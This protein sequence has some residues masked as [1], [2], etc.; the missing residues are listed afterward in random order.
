[1]KENFL[2]NT[3]EFTSQTDRNLSS[4]WGLIYCD[5]KYNDIREALDNKSNNIVIEGNLFYGAYGYGRDA[6]GIFIDHGRGDVQCND[7][8]ILNSQSYSMDSRY[9]K[10]NEASSV[11]NRYERNIVT[12]NYRLMA[13]VC[14]EG[15][16]KPVTNENI[17]LTTKNSKVL[18]IF[19]DEKDQQLM[20]E[21]SCSFNEGKVFVSEALYRLIKKSRAWRYNRN[22]VEKRG[23]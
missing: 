7:N 14:V 5:H 23:L 22:F 12:T 19:T 6:R 3:D 21:R 15:Q 10:R 2:Y 4:D 20:I 8:I 9:V 17:L 18:N 16:N 13:G 11:R 1:M